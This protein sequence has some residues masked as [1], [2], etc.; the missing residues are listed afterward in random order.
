MS[1]AYLG[2]MIVQILGQTSQFDESINKS[3]KVFSGFHDSIIKDIGSIANS[4]KELSK[5]G[6]SL[7]KSLEDAQS[8]LS[9]AQKRMQELINN[10]VSPMSAAYVG[11][12]HNLDLYT[13]QVE[14]AKRQID[15]IGKSYKDTS[16]PMNE[17]I[18][19]TEKQVHAITQLRSQ[20]SELKKQ[21]QDLIIEYANSDKVINEVINVYNEAT[22]SVND[23]KDKIADSKSEIASYRKTWDDLGESFGKGEL[24]ARDLQRQSIELRNAIATTS[25]QVNGYEKALYD[26]TNA[27]EAAKE[28]IAATKEKYAAMVPT[29]D[30][31]KAKYKDL[32]EDI[33]RL[34]SLSKDYDNTLQGLNNHIKD[35]KDRILELLSSGVS[36]YNEEIMKLKVQ[37]DELAGKVAYLKENSKSLNEML[38]ELA[39]TSAKFGAV[40][41]AS[42]TAPLVAAGKAAV[43]SA[44]KLEVS[45]K[46]YE[47]LFSEMMPA[48]T[49]ALYDMQAAYGLTSKQATTFLADASNAFVAM[50]ATRERALE[51]AQSVVQL[52]A[53]ISAYSG[54]P[55]VDVSKALDLALLGNTRNLRNYGLAIRQSA[56]NDELAARGK[57]KLTG[58]ALQLATSEVALKLILEAAQVPLK[59]FAENSTSAAFQSQQLK[60]NIDQLAS[61]L[62]TAM[63]PTIKTIIGDLT[64]F[65]K[66]LDD[67]S[68]STKTGVVVFGAFLA[69]LG[70]IE[71]GIAALTKGIVALQAAMAAGK[72]ASWT[73]LIPL[74]TAA[75]VG[76]TGA[77]VAFKKSADVREQ[78]AQWENL[79]VKLEKNRDKADSLAEEYQKLYEKTNRTAAETK[80]MSE[81]V[82]ELQRL[83][84][85]LTEEM[86]ESGAANQALIDEYNTLKDKTNLT[87]NEQDRLSK[88]TDALNKLYPDFT[89]STKDLSDANNTLKDSINGVAEATD[90]QAK[91]NTLASLSKKINYYAESIVALENEIDRATKGRTEKEIKQNPYIEGWRNSLEKLKK[92]LAEVIAQ[93]NSIVLGE[94]KP[95]IILPFPKEP[96]PPTQ[97]QRLKDLD[98]ERDAMIELAKSTG[99]DV[100]AV[101][102]EYYNKRLN[103][104]YSFLDEDVKANKFTW[105]T[106]GEDLDTT[107]AV[108]GTTIR[109]EISKTV[110]NIDKADIKTSIDEITKALNNNLEAAQKNFEITNGSADAENEANIARKKAY[111]SAIDS[112]ITLLVTNDKLDKTQRESI[113]NWINSYKKQSNALGDII[114]RY[115]NIDSLLKNLENQIN[116]FNEDTN[117]SME[118]LYEGNTAIYKSIGVTINKIKSYKATYGDANGSIQ[119]TID[120][121]I[122]KQKEYGLLLQEQGESAAYTE[123]QK[124]LANINDQVKKNTIDESEAYELRIDAAKDYVKALQNIIDK[125]GDQDHRLS[126]L[127]IT[128]NRVITSRSDLVKIDEDVKKVTDNYDESIRKLNEDYN[129]GNIIEEDAN[130]NRLEAMRKAREELIKYKDVSSE[131]R[132][133]DIRMA[134]EEQELLEKMVNNT[135]A[136]V[137][138]LDKETGDILKQFVDISVKEHG[139]YTRVL[140]NSMTD[141]YASMK[142]FS[143]DSSKTASKNA[144]AVI[145]ISIKLAEEAANTLDDTVRR[146]MLELSDSLMSKL[147]VDAKEVQT[148]VD[149][150]VAKFNIESILEKIKK[151]DES[152]FNSANEYINNFINTGGKYG[153]VLQKE[154]QSRFNDINKA[155]SDNTKAIL[156]ISEKLTNEAVGT[157]DDTVRHKMLNLA[158]DILNMLD[159]DADKVQIMVNEQV[160]KFN[161][162][163]ILEKI[164]GVSKEAYDSTVKYID[165]FLNTGGKYGNEL[166]KYV[167]SVYKTVNTDLSDLLEDLEKQRTNA[168]SKFLQDAINGIIELVNEWSKGEKAVVDIVKDAYAELDRATQQDIVEQIKTVDSGLGE[169]AQKYLDNA[170]VITGVEKDKINAFK[171]TADAM[172]RASDNYKNAVTSANTVFEDNT[173]D[174]KENSAAYIAAQI[175][176]DTAIK[177]ATLSEIEALLKLKGTDTEVN[178]ILIKHR[179]ELIKKGIE[180]N[181]TLKQ[182]NLNKVSRTY[183]ETLKENSER[184]SDNTELN[185]ANQRALEKYISS[186]GAVRDTFGDTDGTVENLI[187]SQSQLLNEQKTEAEIIQGIT[188]ANENYNNTLAE[189]NASN[190]TDIEKKNKI[191]NATIKLRN[192]LLEFI[193]TSQD[194]SDQVKKL[195]IDIN[196]MTAEQLRNTEAN[197]NKLSTY[198]SEQIKF[199]GLAN[200]A[201][202]AGNEA[203]A[204]SYQEMADAYG[205]YVDKINK[206]RGETIEQI[207]LDLLEKVMKA[208]DKR[209]AEF[210]S[211]QIKMVEAMKTAGASVEEINK[212]LAESQ[213]TFDIATVVEEAYAKINATA[214][215]SIY[216]QI[217]LFKFLRDTTVGLTE[218]EKNKINSIISVLVGQIHDYTN[219]ITKL[220]GSEYDKQLV[221]ITSKR[222][223]DLKSLKD[224]QK[225]ELAAIDERQKDELSAEGLTQEEKTEITKKYG[226]LKQAIIKKYADAEVAITEASEKDIAELKKKYLTDFTRINKTELNKRIADIE[227][228]RDTELKS[229][230]E[231]YNSAVAAAKDNASDLEKVDKAYAAKKAE[232]N[233]DATAKIIQA[234][235]DMVSQIT[236]DISSLSKA[237]SDLFSGIEEEQKNFIGD[238]TQ[239]IGG[240]V[241]LFDPIT[242]AIVS[243]IG[244]AFN[245]IMDTMKSVTD[246]IAS[247][248]SKLI[249]GKDMTTAGVQK[250]LKL[251]TQIQTLEQQII[252][253]RQQGEEIIYNQ[254]VD[255]INKAT[256]EELKALD[257]VDEFGNNL[258]DKRRDDKLKE[259]E[260]EKQAQLEALGYVDQYGRDLL[261]KQ[262]QKQ[263]DDIDEREKAELAVLGLL[264]KT[265]SQNLAESITKK[266]REINAETSS[267]RRAILQAELAELTSEKKKADIKQK[268]EDERAAA[269]K[270][271]QEEKAIRDQILFDAETQRLET[272]KQYQIDK[273]K[274][275][276]IMYENQLALQAAEKDYQDKSKKFIHDKAVAEQKLALAEAE[277]AKQKAIHDASKEDKA[278]VEAEYNKVIAAIKALPIPEAQSGMVVMPKR[279]GTIV[280]VA[281]ANMAEAIIPLDRLNQVIA[282]INTKSFQ[283]ASA[284]P[285]DLGDIHLVVNLDDKPILEKIFP[286][287]R[288]RTVKIDARS[289]VGNI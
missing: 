2:Q 150:Q 275:D 149:E 12:K 194:A 109:Q 226:E 1:G 258:L 163:V 138:K 287:T 176:R 91:A 41:S 235:L 76:L 248:L 288:N 86:I 125:Y 246:T 112:L 58:S 64:K 211:S 280:K 3:E 224:M 157:L 212:K 219:D 185:K 162:D 20:H 208:Q 36:P 26:L 54:K 108:F 165:D 116:L 181:E 16:N 71:L 154:M 65:V 50:G 261:D 34:E 266:Q 191:L 11:A 189:I 82:Y 102:K 245:S 282:S 119:K 213:R 215:A 206:K 127:I 105:A 38:N 174:I 87:A 184:I 202:L 147:H 267:R 177:D 9:E 217:N 126:D 197:E 6:M 10:G 67:I 69:L 283:T 104:L 39:K 214:S 128:T 254:K 273:E 129:K 170:K 270:K 22:K 85:D 240:I 241:S 238:L 203:L 278:A 222:D 121:L 77:I 255:D 251:T 180:L 98:T 53:A 153:A 264:D 160:A 272:E 83:Y 192:S 239:G 171:N 195:N 5:N 237:F 259:I 263:L 63:M 247:S 265:E 97:G 268:Y 17:F 183:T 198:I 243:S 45:S 52:T 92:D 209:T 158:S 80:R 134:K 88:V 172:K 166:V 8:R 229:L 142:K 114:N 256:Q 73:T 68:D 133:A 89:K 220:I 123:Y 118:D 81:I 72:L 204:K 96:P 33:K 188:K 93:Y 49:K 151:I 182:E 281:E 207:E 27:Q 24:L 101:E 131:A 78:E 110:A 115:V 94:K 48:A 276:K 25:K 46:K 7:S 130:K 141:A 117:K 200:E 186:L 143:E 152:A 144:D 253:Y 60:A 285:T 169:I 122:V 43:E 18:G 168:K 190:D 234:N 56:V 257:Y 44:E 262:H 230:E 145:A 284:V 15:E 179:D 279:G 231:M 260:K 90:K 95:S 252:G 23:M 228:E 178:N 136:A 223:A 99:Q 146:K 227:N 161:I 164:N 289:I 269:E 242:G 57:D 37:N 66:S 28:N 199:Q 40:L 249:Y 210:Y 173:R 106:I 113:E 35:N 218:D 201:T 236:S 19:E 187:I 148:I 167:E 155:A 13:R 277:I 124:Q 250:R 62:G 75:V 59:T 100:A 55:M 175:K 193:G 103:L 30:E 233:K 32:T 221:N 205:E 47:D 216:E 4:T 61:S 31:L 132:D 274:R 14:T 79:S 120:D 139:G 70:P 137:N 21:I 111:D 156:A 286:A 196:N 29:I 74:V 140:L 159:E 135:L 42:V 84:P 51:M 107:L 232:I 271:Y 244:K 225:D